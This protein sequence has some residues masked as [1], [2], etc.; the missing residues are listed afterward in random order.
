MT[1]GRETVAE[2][3]PAFIAVGFLAGRNACYSIFGG[4]IVAWG[5][6]GP[7]LV[8]MGAAFGEGVSPSYPGYMN[9]MNMGESFE[10]RN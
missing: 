4:A 1:D 2:F 7:T 9:Y 3:T 8:S 10:I 6:I 5:I